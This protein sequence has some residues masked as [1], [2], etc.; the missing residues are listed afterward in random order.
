[1][2][3]V[4]TQP[5][6]AKIVFALK[7]CCAALLWAQAEQSAQRRQQRPTAPAGLRC[8]RFRAVCRG[9]RPPELRGH[10]ACCSPVVEPCAAAPFA[11]MPVTSV[12]ELRVLQ[13]C[14]HPNL[15][16]L[17]RVVT[18]KAL[19]RMAQCAAGALSHD[20]H[21]AQAETMPAVCHGGCMFLSLITHCS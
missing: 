17:K 19:A 6:N 14:K 15:V 2:G 13:T 5:A 20:A 10:A 12:R 1:M 4:L 8:V 7:A 3:A 11:G 9:R 18:G 16:E 21:P